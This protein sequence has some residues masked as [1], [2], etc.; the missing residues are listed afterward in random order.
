MDGAQEAECLLL[1]GRG[2]PFQ[3]PQVGSCLTLGNELSNE[4]YVLTEQETLLGK[5][6]WGGGQEDKGTQEDCSTTC[7]RLY[8]D[9]LVSGL[10]LVNHSDSGSSLLAHALLCQDGCQR[11][12]F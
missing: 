7:L 11:E 10:S 4:T 6:A 8:G 5:G 2:D 3:G 1:A 12:G 9:G